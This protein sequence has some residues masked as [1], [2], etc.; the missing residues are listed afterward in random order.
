MVYPALLPLMRTPWLPV[1]DWTDAPRRFKCT[2]PFRWKTKSDL[3]V[4]WVFVCS[5]R[6]P[7]CNAHGPYCH[8]WPARFHNILPHYL[9]KG[10]I[11][12]GKGSR[13]WSV[14]SSTTLSATLII[15][16]GIRSSWTVPGIVVRFLMKF[17]FS[18]DIFG[19]LR[20]QISWKYFQSGP[21]CSKR[22]NR[23]IW[24]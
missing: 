8:L 21:S 16:G 11:F 18:R 2:R 19:L 1:V 20:Y 22:T 3:Y 14:S 7:A 10:T 13:T 4:F 24:S 9:K 23:R 5:L 15:L 6:Y 12:G 17:A